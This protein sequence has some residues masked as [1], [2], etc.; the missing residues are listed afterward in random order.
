MTFLMRQKSKEMLATRARPSGSITDP[1]KTW[2]MN[3][4][5]LD[6][7]RPIEAVGYDSQCTLYSMTT[8]RA[9]R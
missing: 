3:Q 6:R 8:L 2:R 1:V 4:L 9:T 7:L 5:Q